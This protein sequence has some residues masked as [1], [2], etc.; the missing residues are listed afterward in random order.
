[1][2]LY[3]KNAHEFKYKT[4]QRYVARP[5]Q[6]HGVDNIFYAGFGNTLYD[7]HAYHKAG[8]DLHRMFLIDKQS[9]IHCLDDD[10]SDEQVVKELLRHPKEYAF[11]R[12]T[13]FDGYKDERLL[14]HVL[15]Y[16]KI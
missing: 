9:K 1:M 14:S 4:L 16:K 13:L 5:F 7:M 10:T 2:D 11:T 3:A 8:M 12:G 6:D 15:G